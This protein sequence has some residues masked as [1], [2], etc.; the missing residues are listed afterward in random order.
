MGHGASEFIAKN[1]SLPTEEN[2]IFWIKNFA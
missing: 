1:Y 2:Y